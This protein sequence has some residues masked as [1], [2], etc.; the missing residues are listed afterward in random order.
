MQ[1]FPS[2]VI[3]LDIGA[4]KTL[5]GLVTRR[6]EITLT[7]TVATPASPSAILSS[8]RALCESLIAD[9]RSPIIG[10]GIGSAGMIDTKTKTVIFANDNLP[11]WSG[12]RL[13]DIA[14]ADLP[15]SAENDVRALA[16]G[17]AMLGAGRE[18]SSLLCLT[19]GTGIGG[20]IIMN[21]EIWHGADFSAGEIGYLVVG[22][23][24]ESPLILDQFASGPAIERAY[25]AAA[26]GKK[27]LPLTA[28][29]Q[30][31]RD[32]DPLA[33]EVITRK[34]RKLGAILAGLVATINPQAVVIG[35]GVP[36]I[37]A[38]WWDA[39]RAAFRASAP[40][41]VKETPLLPAALGV[42]AVL[43]GAAMLAWRELAE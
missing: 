34:A 19:V 29:N 33:A 4:T 5:A 28:I 22:W 20:A 23:E 38:L 17:E 7:R 12:T 11:G 43:L 31:A 40:A 13:T 21:G 37:G 14:I 42:E 41:P 16:F 35:G 3:G 8:A 9:S 15:L 6:G 2:L 27:R 1:E 39:L 24:G 30:R 32:S 18:F 25:Q 10:I 26:N 36:A